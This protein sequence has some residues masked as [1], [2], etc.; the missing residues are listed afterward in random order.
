MSA[1][2]VLKKNEELSNQLQILQK[3]QNIRNELYNEF[4]NAFKDYLNGKCPSEQ[5]YSVCK[6][7]TE[8]FQE[9]SMTIQ[10]VEKEIS[11]SVISN[12]IRTL[13]QAEK[14]KLEKTA[15]NQILIIKAKETDKDY[16]DDIRQNEECLEMISSRI[17]DI[18]DEIREEIHQVASLVC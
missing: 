13:Q 6:I 2:T 8:G 12:M 18:W 14:E 15:Y 4:D 5:Y 7:V 11:D 9:V 1:D 16:D 10:K 17:Q 3:E